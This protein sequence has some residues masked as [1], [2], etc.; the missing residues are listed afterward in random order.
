MSYTPTTLQLTW[1]H[2]L[3]WHFGTVH[4]GST[5]TRWRHASR[6]ASSH[7]L[8]LKLAYVLETILWLAL[9][10]RIK[11]EFANS[12]LWLTKSSISIHIWTKTDY[13]CVV[14]FGQHITVDKKKENKYVWIENEKVWRGFVGSWDAFHWNRKN[15][16]IRCKKTL[17]NRL[18]VSLSNINLD[19]KELTKNK[20]LKYRDVFFVCRY[21]NYFQL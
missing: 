12:E 6:W 16:E 10:F 5:F 1:H 19:P 9:F 14:V 13:F 21:L 20:C 2:W 18:R 8:R 4:A 17:K 11:I 7:H 15:L 3:A